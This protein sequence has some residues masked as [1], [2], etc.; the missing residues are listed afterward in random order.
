MLMILEAVAWVFMVF[1]AGVVG[2]L[3]LAATP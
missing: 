2:V 3:I 1:L